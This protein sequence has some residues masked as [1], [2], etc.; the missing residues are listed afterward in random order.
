MNNNEVLWGI[1][2]NGVKRHIVFLEYDV[3]N[4]LFDNVRHSCDL[5]MS[6]SPWVL[7][8]K[9]AWNEKKILDVAQRLK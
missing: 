4:V 2:P 7:D 6:N 5:W 3:N 9:W 1:T 8:T